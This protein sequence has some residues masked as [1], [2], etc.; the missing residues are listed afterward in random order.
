MEKLKAEI[1]GKMIFM[2]RTKLFN[3]SFATPSKIFL[4]PN[5][6]K[7]NRLKQ[8]SEG[9]CIH[10]PQ[11]K[12]LHHEVRIRKVLNSLIVD[13]GALC[14]KRLT[15]AKAG[16]LTEH[17]IFQ[18]E[19]PV[20]IDRSRKK[21]VEDLSDTPIIGSPYKTFSNIRPTNNAQA[22]VILK[23]LGN[24]PKLTWKKLKPII[25]V[26]KGDLLEL[27]EIAYL[28]FLSKIRESNGVNLGTPNAKYFKFSVGTGNNSQLVQR[29]IRSR[30]W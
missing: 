1:T 21:R 30:W 14:I 28:E 11:N 16:D 20:P 27:R 9:T 23:G 19:E 13:P 10:W 26:Q 24:F 29:V 15:N 7:N 5:Y 4:R 17:K 22:S 3:F 18:R 2:D 8:H 6:S 25:S 12:E